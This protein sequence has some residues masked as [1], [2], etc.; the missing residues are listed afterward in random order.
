MRFM[1]WLVDHPLVFF[2]ATLALL[3]AAAELGAL[4]RIRG[5]KL[6]DAER[7]EFDLVRA[8]MFTLFGL[9]VGFAITMAVSRFDLRKSYEEAEANAIG[10]ENLRL[11]FLSPETASAARALLKAYAEKRIVFYTEL[12][13]ERLARNEIETAATQ[14]ALWEA[15]VPA[16]KKEPTPIM[17]LTVSGMNDVLNSQGYTLSVFRNRLPVEVWMLLTV[18]AVACNFLIGFGAERLSPATHA[19]LPLAAALAFLLISDV[20]GP[21]NGLVRVHPVNIEDAAR[22]I[23]VN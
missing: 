4:A 9:L 16:A 12:D 5:H 1:L 8:A 2:V 7:A 15:I 10:T 17:G 13:A 18:T 3:F 19:V 23:G 22:A 14:K 21:R 11:D 6:T 20:E